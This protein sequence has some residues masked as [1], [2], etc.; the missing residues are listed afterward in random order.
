M[1]RSFALG[2]I[3]VVVVASPGCRHGRTEAITGDGTALTADLSP[4]IL[5]KDARAHVEF[6]ASDACGGRLTG[7][8]GALRAAF[9]IMGAY[10]NARLQPISGADG[11]SQPFEFTAGVE[12]VPGRAKMEIPLGLGASDG[13]RSCKLDEDFRPVAFSAN[14]AVEG[15]VVF[16][17]YG[18]VQPQSRG[19]GYDS[20]VGLDVTG[21]IVLALRHLPEDITPERRQE[22]SIYASDRYKARLAADR[23]A[24]GF[25]LVTGP[26]SPHPG[27]LVKLRRN[28]RVSAGP[29]VAVS[30]SGDLAERL[31]KLAHLDDLETLQTAHDDGTINPH[32][33]RVL[34]GVRVRVAAELRR[35]RKTCDNVIGVLP[36]TGGATDYV[37][38]GAHYDH[39]GDGVGLGSLA[40]Q[41]EEGQI[42]NGA[43]DNASGTA[44]VLELAAAVADARRNADD[45][46]P[47]RGVIFAC[48]SGEELGIIGSSRFAADPPIPLENIVAYFNFDMVGRMR[49]DK[50]VVQAVGSS[51]VW[52]DMIRQ[53]AEN[54]DFNLTTQ[55]DPYLPTDITAFYTKGVPGL[56]FFTGSHQDYNRPTDDADTLNYEGLERIA[57]LAKCLIEE[58][59]A[60]DIEIAYIRVKR[61]TPAGPRGGVRAYTGTIP[62]YA[63]SDVEG[64]LL[65]DVRA[66]G[67]AEKAGLK[68]G[69]VIVEFAGRKISN[70][71]DYS[72][73][74]IGVKIGR[75]VKVVVQRD[76]ERLSFTITP[77][78][79]PG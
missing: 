31:L 20:Y 53:C 29:V 63:T 42:H 37:M 66:G 24:G 48:W 40:R 47:R 14:G 2:V 76:G 39:I 25:L 59:T 21:K 30:I 64:V 58:T 77:T 13:F 41:G 52:P 49:G 10:V 36:P 19:E 34:K 43:D 54:A 60:P 27:R 62:D 1:S 51:P 16:V 75:P 67:P 68:G 56:S 70:L 15:E 9:Y 38:V 11:Y 3:C 69:D 50:L 65:S 72:D 45:T 18:I 33:E 46:A 23:G 71:Q 6:L 61:A 26:N 73:A 57:T 55:D 7:S 8:L 74:L 79:R 35:V 17:G 12:M 22:L 28:D 44:A 78:V 4:Q 32:V 5:A